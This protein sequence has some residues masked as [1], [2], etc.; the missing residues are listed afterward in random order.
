MLFVRKNGE[1]FCA[2]PCFGIITPTHIIQRKMYHIFFMMIPFRKCTQI[3][4]TRKIRH[5]YTGIKFIFYPP[6]PLLSRITVSASVSDQL[7]TSAPRAQAASGVRPSPQNKP[8]YC[9]YSPKNLIWRCDR[10]Q[11]PQ[12]SQRSLCHS[13]VLILQR[14]FVRNCWLTQISAAEGKRMRNHYH[15]V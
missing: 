8:I 12:P 4:S 10:R 6:R 3:K 1:M 14:K 7:H 13:I 2:V 9:A 5:L 15:S 11:R